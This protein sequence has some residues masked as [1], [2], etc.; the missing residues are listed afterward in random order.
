M[1]RQRLLDADVCCLFV[2]GREEGTQI[3][4][5]DQ[6]DVAAGSSRYELQIAIDDWVTQ[7]GHWINAFAGW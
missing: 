3:R 7:S 1:E 2:D 4:H 5:R 6:K